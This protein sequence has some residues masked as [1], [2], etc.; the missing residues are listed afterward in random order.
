MNAQKARQVAADFDDYLESI[1]PVLATKFGVTEVSRT[2][3]VNP[4]QGEFIIDSDISSEKEN[5][6]VW[7][8]MYVGSSNPDVDTLE[9]DFINLGALKYADSA[10]VSKEAETVIFT[11][12]SDIP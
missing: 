12:K 6:T 3:Q 1:A 9:A 11:L 10:T 4:G 8:E 5:V 2:W 7:L